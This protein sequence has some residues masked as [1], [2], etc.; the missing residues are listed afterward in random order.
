M[1]AQIPQAPQAIDEKQPTTKQN[2]RTRT[3]SPQ[4]Q[5][6]TGAKSGPGA[7]FSAAC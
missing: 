5:L 7:S 6:E 4:S 2:I 3:P 1:S